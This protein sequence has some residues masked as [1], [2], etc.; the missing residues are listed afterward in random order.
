[1]SVPNR[2]RGARGGL[3]LNPTLGERPARLRFATA[4][5]PRQNFPLLS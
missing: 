2:T 4:G 1:M 3:G 5:T